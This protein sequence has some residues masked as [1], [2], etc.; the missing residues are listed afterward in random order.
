MR[1]ELAAG[2]AA[3]AVGTV[4]LNSATYLDM[5]GRGRPSSTVPADAAERL[6]QLAHVQLGDEETAPNRQEALGALL[7]LLTGLGV[8]A[9]FGVVRSKIDVPTPFAAVGM[10]VAAMVG[11]D[12]PMTALGLTD[13]REWDAVSWV[14]DLLPHLAYG[15]AAAVA[16]RIFDA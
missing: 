15:A 4:A 10:G 1:S 14:A 13:P 11:S 7:G 5:L 6:G 3:G 8:G 12:L 9:A 16:Y 2:I